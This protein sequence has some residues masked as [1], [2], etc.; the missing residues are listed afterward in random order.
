MFA[1][2]FGAIVW[3]AICWLLFFVFA[4]T[5]LLTFTHKRHKTALF[6]AILTG[7]FATPALWLL[8]EFVWAQRHG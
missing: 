2:A 5:A 8:F 3:F 4:I 7:A 1:P 6:F